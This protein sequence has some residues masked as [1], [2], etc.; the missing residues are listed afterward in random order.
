MDDTGQH[1]LL[2]QAA[3]GTGPVGTLMTN[4]DGQVPVTW[5]GEGRSFSPDG[6]KLVFTAL[7][8]DGLWDLHLLK[9][10]GEQRSEPLLPTRLEKNWSE[11]GAAISP[12]GRWIAYHSNQTGQWE[13]YVRSFPKVTD[14]V[15]Q[16]SQDGGNRPVW[17]PDGREL[18]YRRSPTMMAVPIAAET[19][20][21]F[22]NPEALFDRSF[23]PYFGY[24]VAPDGQRF[25]IYRDI[26]P[27]EDTPPSNELI[28]VLNWLA[29]LQSRTLAE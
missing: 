16:V 19:P 20:L 17:G 21:A 10:N 24:D 15:L 22:G 13:V 7:R 4:T 26:E 25:L 5:E 1:N 11:G 3:D 12:N 2:S 6:K 23:L 18:F 14:R 29:E 9:M 8:S 27:T 28:V